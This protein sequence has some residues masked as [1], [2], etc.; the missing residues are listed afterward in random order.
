MTD[1]EG[2]LAR[3]GPSIACGFTTAGASFSVVGLL[4]AV[5]VIGSDRL[6]RGCGQRCYGW[7][8]LTPLGYREVVL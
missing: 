2:L 3:K 4:A 7:A 8:C 5:L 6:G 1:G